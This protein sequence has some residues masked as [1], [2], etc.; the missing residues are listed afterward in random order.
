MIGGFE[1]TPASRHRRL[2]ADREY[3]ERRAERARLDLARAAQPHDLNPQGHR[4]DCVC[5][6]CFE[7]WMSRRRAALVERSRA[8]AL[9]R[10]AR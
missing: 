7:A 6:R 9:L 3:Q 4:S 1:E 2:V 10:T 5:R 8:V